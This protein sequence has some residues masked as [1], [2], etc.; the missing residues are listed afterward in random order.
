VG[1]VPLGIAASQYL[2]KR[3]DRLLGW[4]GA[5][6][7]WNEIQRAWE[8]MEHDRRLASSPWRN[9]VEGRVRSS[10]D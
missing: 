8:E 2:P 9:G 5:T 4:F 1:L 6:R 3:F 7:S 10:R